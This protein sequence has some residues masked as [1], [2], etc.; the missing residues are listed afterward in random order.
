MITPPRLLL[1][2]L[3]SLVLAL[4]VLTVPSPAGAAITRLCTGYTSCA[5]AGM[6]SA[7]YAQANGQMYWRMYSGHNC[8]N[9]AAYRVIKNGYSSTRPWD[10]SGN[11]T[12]WG[13]EMSGITDRTPAVGAIAWWRAG[14]YPAGSAGHVAYVEKVVSP[15][16]IIV[17]QDSWGGDFSWARITST[18]GWPSGFIHFNDQKPVMNNVKRPAISGDLE[19]G[20]T[21]E[22]TRGGWRPRGPQVVYEWR[23][24]GE[25][26]QTGS[27]N[28]LELTKALLGKRVKVKVTASKSGYVDA[29]ARSDRTTRIQPGDMTS[30]RVPLIE[31]TPEVGQTLAADGGRWS[32]RAQTRAFQWK[33]DGQPLDG[34]TGRRLTLTPDLVDK[35]MT[36]SVTA[37]HEGYRT[38]TAT[39]AGTGPVAAAPIVVEEEPVM[40]GTPLLGETLRLTTV[41][42]ASPDAT[43]SLQWMRDGTPV[44]GATTR[45]YELTRD[46]L[47][48]SITA[49]VTWSR[50]GYRDAVEETPTT[51]PVRSVPTVEHEVVAGT[52]KLVVTAT[53]R[54]PGVGVVPG[55]L[56]VVRHGEVLAEKPVAED[57]TVRLVVREQRAGERSYRIVLP[58]TDV[59]TKVVTLE[60]VTI[61]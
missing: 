56:R 33:A 32:P 40:E 14:V 1:H 18:S 26:I 13:T 50:E 4:A 28:T 5:N 19:V 51:E 8:T 41:G 6:G 37:T 53:V 35:V 43:R 45:R 25:A 39:S 10:G 49:R 58:A 55:V 3:G 36:V 11:A 17:S 59:T 42:T 44:R 57:G 21:L 47:G 24:G 60:D 54:A 9:Y 22:A 2:A 12:Y 15:T 31:G 20:S 48:S 30:A 23:S 7:G 46:D 34:A 27:Q 61:G 52:G 16:E 38:L 29:S